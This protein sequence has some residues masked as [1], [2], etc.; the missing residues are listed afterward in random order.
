MKRHLRLGQAQTPDDQP[1]TLD[2]EGD[3]LVIR[4]RGEA[5]MSSR[6]H[7]SEE[8]LAELGLAIW[9]AHPDP[10]FEQRLHQTGL[11]ASS[12]HVSA[13]GLTQKGPRH[14]VFLAQRSDY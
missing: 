4:V 3:A 9:S 6:Q 11:R 13:R 2:Q 7:G 5:L 12:H 10:A 1:L 14:V 8:R